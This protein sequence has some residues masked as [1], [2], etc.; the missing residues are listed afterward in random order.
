MPQRRVKGADVDVMVDEYSRRDKRCTDEAFA[1]YGI[2][3]I[4][5]GDGGIRPYC[6]CEVEWWVN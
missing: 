2:I 3:G 5:I 1:V 4:L 6:F